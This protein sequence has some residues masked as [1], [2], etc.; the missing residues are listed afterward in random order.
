MTAGG[1]FITDGDAPS[2]Q[3]QVSIGNEVSLGWAIKLQQE[4]M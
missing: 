1:G 2:T 4:N 3:L